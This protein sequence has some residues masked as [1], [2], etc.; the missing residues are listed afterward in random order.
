MSI[1]LH[2]TTNFI[3]KYLHFIGFVLSVNSVNTYIELITLE[4]LIWIVS[5]YLLLFTT[6]LTNEEWTNLQRLQW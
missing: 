4:F 3:L 2:K 6:P 5:A 1:R